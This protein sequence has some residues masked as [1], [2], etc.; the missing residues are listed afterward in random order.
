MKYV[1]SGRVPKSE[2][3][4]TVEARSKTI[5]EDIRRTFEAKNAANDA[6]FLDVTVE[7]MK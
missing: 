2:R 6:L 5:A 1:V 3:R 7:E 4:I